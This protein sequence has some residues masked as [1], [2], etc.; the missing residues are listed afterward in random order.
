MIRKNP[1]FI[2]TVVV[3]WAVAIYVFFFLLKIGPI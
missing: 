1:K 3:L 2:A